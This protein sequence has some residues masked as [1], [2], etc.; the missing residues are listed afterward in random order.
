MKAARK[1]SS[2]IEWRSRTR[3][4]CTMHVCGVDGVPAGY[5]ACG[6]VSRLVMRIMVK[7]GGRETF[8]DFVP[9]I[10]LGDAKA[11]VE[12]CISRR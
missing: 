6:A 11:V 2:K 5:V 10:S 7:I 8:A 3:N 4:G 12:K 1:T 9:S